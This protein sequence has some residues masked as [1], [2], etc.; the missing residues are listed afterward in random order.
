MSHPVLCLRLRGLRGPLPPVSA[1]CLGVA[2]NQLSDIKYSCL[3]LTTPQ[4]A[5]RI[6]RAPGSVAFL[7]CGSALQPILPRSQC[8]CINEDNSRFVLQIRRPQYWRIEIPVAD[9]P[10]VFRAALLRDV[11]DKILLFEKTEC[12]FERSFT[13]QLPDPPETPV[14]KKAWTAEGK[15]LI[16]SAFQSDLSPPGHEPKAIN[17]G[18][19]AFSHGISLANFEP[20]ADDKAQNKYSLGAGDPSFKENVSD[21]QVHKDADAPGRVSLMVFRA[22]S[23]HDNDLIVRASERR[24]VNPRTSLEHIAQDPTVVSV[25]DFSSTSIDLRRYS[26]VLNPDI[27]LDDTEASHEESRSRLLE[28]HG[29]D[30]SNRQ[31]VAIKDNES[32]LHNSLHRFEE[33]EETAGEELSGKENEPGARGQRAQMQESAVV[34]D[35]PTTDSPDVVIVKAQAGFSLSDQQNNVIFES[36]TSNTEDDPAPFEGS[37]R[38]APVDLARKRM[39]R[40]LAGRSFT[41]PPQLTPFVSPSTLEKQATGG[42]VMP[43]QPQQCLAKE[44]SPSASTDSFHTV[45]SWHSSS[46]PPLV[47]PCPDAPGMQDF[48]P[49]TETDSVGLPGPSSQVSFSSDHTTTPKNVINVVSSSSVVSDSCGSA[50]P[51]PR[52]AQFITDERYQEPIDGESGVG[53]SRLSTLEDKLRVRRRSHAG[54]LSGRRRALSPLPP[55]A[56]IFSPSPRQTSRSRLAAAR[57]LPKTILQKTIEIL[58][59]PP[60]H[61]ISLML[62]VAA[63]I[64]A[65]EWRGLV[66]GF[67]EAG[68]Q[69]P[70]QWDYYSDGE[71]SDLGESDDYALTT[72]S[73]DYGDSVPRT[74]LRHRNRYARGDHQDNSEVD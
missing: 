24:A 19:R 10:D 42:G 54:S 16:S 4:G 32:Y 69:I 68:E 63:K 5:F 74:E 7:S 61:L 45:Q 72:H 6:Y 13:V 62:K 44:E 12:P 14:K 53:L 41:A 28:A 51:T 26:E 40:M 65:G 49:E 21:S 60:S 1:N 59:S 37:G 48:S 18:E 43:P 36:D 25:P 50:E 23:S 39:S 27:D 2:D 46:T 15:N 73:S 31:P 29:F 58:L 20:T 22:L 47:S 66:F 38:V 55:A 8:W 56:N 33:H 71:F 34:S 3:V 9:P 67:G 11:F 17:R 57:R 64:A 52:L 70:V 30:P 35:S